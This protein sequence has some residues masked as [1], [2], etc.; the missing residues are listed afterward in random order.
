MQQQ[1]DDKF[2]EQ[3]T[4][5]DG[6]SPIHSSTTHTGDLLSS[7]GTTP[8]VGRVSSRA[9]SSLEESSNLG[10][11]QQAARPNLS[12]PEDTFP[13]RPDSPLPGRRGDVSMQGHPATMGG[14]SEPLD[15][16]SEFRED[17]P[18]SFDHTAWQSRGSQSGPAQG[19]KPDVSRDT[20]SSRS[21]MSTSTAEERPV[22]PTGRPPQAY[23]CR[24]GPFC[25]PRWS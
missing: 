1:P 21:I 10:D 22:Q 18:S 6:R 9:Q 7:P 8:E 19:A 5:Q 4:E 25:A 17:Q 20:R 11:P 15:E 3:G 2:A 23:L 12:T 14:P 13:R 16:F 24:P